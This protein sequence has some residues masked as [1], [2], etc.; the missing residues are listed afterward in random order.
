MKP[1]QWATCLLPDAMVH[2]QVERALDILLS[3]EAPPSQWIASRKEAKLSAG[4]KIMAH[5]VRA[6]RREANFWKYLVERDI[7]VV[8]CFR[9]NILMQLIS[10][11]ITMVTRQP[12]CWDGQV[13]TAKVTVNIPALKGHFNRILDEKA[14]LIDKVAETGLRNRKIFYEHFKDDVVPAEELFLWLTGKPAKLSTKLTKQNPDDLR[15]RVTN[16]DELVEEVKRLGFD[17]LLG[18]V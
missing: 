17:H 2:N 12:A 14:Y 18:D 6:L 7:P 8:I 16:Y 11:L 9:N 13:K 15:E 10:D 1:V 3:S 4:F 5:Q